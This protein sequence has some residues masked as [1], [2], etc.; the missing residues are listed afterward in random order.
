[1]SAPAG[2]P[3]AEAAAAAAGAPRLRPARRGD[4]A[5]L[6][7]LGAALFAPFGDYREALA[8]WLRSPRVVTRVVVDDGDRPLGFLC[9]TS[10]RL[11]DGSRAAYILAVAVARSQQRR[12]LARSMIAAMLD[13][14]SRRRVRCA[15]VALSAAAD[16][17]AARALFRGL[18]F[19]ETGMQHAAYAP[20]RPGVEMRR[21]LAVVLAALSCLLA[22]LLPPAPALA[23]NYRFPSSPED[24]SA[25]Y[26]TAY[27]D[28]GGVTD[29]DCGNLTYSGHQGSDFGGG[30]WAGMDAG[31]DISAGAD[32]QVI[33]TNDGVA[34]DCSTGDCPG[35]GGF[36][37]YVAL[38]HADGKATY[39]AHLKTWSLTVANGDTVSCGQKLGEM[40][41]SG[42]STG[43]HVHFEV[44]VNGGASDPFDGPCSG[45]PSY[46]VD[47]G[48]HGGLPA[49]LCDGAAGC[50]PVGALSC[51]VPISAANTDAGSTQ[52]ELSWPSPCN[53]FTYT[54]REIAWTWTAAVSESVSAALTG[55]GADLDLFVLDGAGCDAPGSCP[56]ASTNP[57]SS[58]ESVTWNAVAGQTYTL[59]VDGWEGATSS[60]TLSLACTPASGDDDDA[61]TA[62]DD[63]STAPG[64]D[65][66]GRDDDDDSAA[67][68]PPAFLPGAERVRMPHGDGGGCQ[69][70]KG[71]GGGGGGSPASALAFLL[72]AALLS[73][74]RRARKGASLLSVLLAACV[75]SGDDDFA[76][77]DP[78]DD[79][80][81]DPAAACEEPVEGFVRLQ[82]L[83]VERGFD[84]EPR[85][86][87]QIGSSASWG[88]LEAA[89]AADLDADGDADA[90]FGLFDEGVLLYENDGRGFFTRRAGRVP[91]PPGGGPTLALAA[92][93]LDGDGLPEILV[94][95]LGWL[96]VSWNLGALEFSEP[97]ALF[98]DS[99][100]PKDC[101]HTLGLGDADGD[102]D[103]DV[104]APGLDAAEGPDSVFDPD[105]SPAGQDR[106]IL[107]ESGQAAA[108]MPLGGAGHPP[109]SILSVFTD[110]DGD[111]DADLLVSA[112]RIHFSGEIPQAFYRNDGP[113]ALGAPVLVN[114]A[115][116]IG[117][118][119][120][121]EGMGE[122]AADWNGDGTLD[123]CLSDIRNHLACLVS[124]GGGYYDAGLAMGLVVD[125][126]HEAGNEGYSGWSL[127]AEDFGN[128]GV[129]DLAMVAGAVPGLPD[130][131]QPDALFQ[132]L[133]TGGFSNRS[134]ESGFSSLDHH[135]AMVSADFEGD[136]Y[137]DLLVAPSYT[138]PMFWSNPCGSGDWLELELRGPP[139]NSAAIGAR[140]E[141]RTGDRVEL[142]EVQGPRALGQSVPALH[143]GLG[144]GVDEVDLEV[145]WPDG[146]VTSEAASPSSS[147]IPTRPH[148]EGAC[149]ALPFP[150]RRWRTRL[151]SGCGEDSP[152]IGQ[153]GAHAAPCSRRLD[154]RG[155]RSGLRHRARAG[156][157]RRLRG[158]AGRRQRRQRP[159]R[160][161]DELRSSPGRVQPH[162][163]AGR[164][165]GR[166]PRVPRR[167][168]AHLVLGRP[169]RRRRARPG[170]RRRRRSPLLPAG[171][172]PL[173]LRQRRRR[174][175]RVARNRARRAGD[176][177]PPARL[178]RRRGPERRR[179]SRRHRDRGRDRRRLVE[180]GG[181]RF[182]GVRDP[183]HAGGLP[184]RLLQLRRVRRRRR[185]RRPRPLR[186]GPGRGPLRGLDR[187]GLP[188][189]RRAAFVLA[190]PAPARRRL[191]RL[192]ARAGAHRSG[193]RRTFHPGVLHRP[194]QRRRSRHLPQ[195][196]PAPDP[197][198]PAVRVLSERQRGGAGAARA[199]RRCRGHRRR[200]PNLRHG[201]G[202]GGSERRRAPRLLHERRERAVAVPAERRRGWRRLLRGRGGP[203]PR[204]GAP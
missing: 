194:G 16:N 81:P 77:A 92:A 34:D 2:Q 135:F 118:D 96:G 91:P 24:Y 130:Q 185:R 138:V 39:Y 120:R 183:V 153:R 164:G 37:N 32:G 12:G 160:P 59:A 63:D 100:W 6:V 57:E 188:L 132:G 155:Q 197:R 49:L 60:F 79:P 145:T 105:G 102:G 61:T 128:D 33:A 95:S 179:A 110:R 7:Q 108:V 11:A 3:G 196:R 182:L 204:G 56:G 25:F 90:G 23:Q 26:P 116:S 166:R 31:R 141:L 41:S 117:A 187:R 40:G 73:L 176:L 99:D 172:L 35:G 180:P 114:D 58:D 109:K 69:D 55:L 127:E 149:A 122:A 162:R 74:P 17:T 21:P 191:R 46:W 195:L 65:D 152:C 8:G 173:A 192:R 142:R 115:A 199:L 13:E 136:G 203:R 107:L 29:W 98:A 140:V 167:S 53:E 82:D 19:R 200:P 198:Q 170:P 94:G 151:S 52:A 174:P 169:R 45:P 184:L 175:F 93:D 159:R 106:L 193:P 119:L 83:A 88:G 44:R 85:G 18:G 144:A 131:A 156:R 36:G 101:L 129:L 5:T 165:S 51:G 146:T 147:S 178:A 64:D 112:D 48:T 134:A 42:Y 9:W 121:I 54:G 20:D 143:F 27:K 177:R 103:L 113:D 201:P 104:F 137:R 68:G 157:R 86:V 125:D 4:H 38:Q 43:P 181:A 30:S 123:Y 97:D 126:G 67:D 87:P 10:G 148:D 150:W 1:M 78:T 161:R 50:V 186:A 72:G 89:F 133:A 190:L 202:L 84:W 158:D 154:R 71:A 189:R 47:Q 15:E 66:S 168:D 62:G 171:R 124:D 80:S 22:P 76:T 75:A 70:C 163:R 28:Q 111:G 14:L 139:G